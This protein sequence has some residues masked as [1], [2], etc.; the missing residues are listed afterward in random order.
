MV[1]IFPPVFSI[2]IFNSY[3][4]NNDTASFLVLQPVVDP[5]KDKFSGMSNSQRLD[6]LMNM[7]ERNMESGVDYIVTPETAVDSIWITDPDDLLLNKVKKFSAKYPGTGVVLGATSFASLPSSERSFTTREDE[8]GNFF[9][10]HNSALY[11]FSGYYSGAY[12]K[13]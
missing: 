7:A 8:E 2:H 6:Q 4:A 11:F 13:H 5:Y 3:K 10:I 12:H 1:L 9:E